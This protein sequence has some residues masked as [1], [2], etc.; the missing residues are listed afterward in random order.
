VRQRRWRTRRARR[1]TVG[2]LLAVG[3]AA[4]V[5]VAILVNRPA[6]RTGLRLDE[7]LSAVTDGRV[8]SATI[9]DGSH[10]VEGDLV[11]R[12]RYRVVVPKDYL[13]E[14][15]NTL[16]RA[17]P[18]IRLQAR[19]TGGWRS[20]VLRVVVPLVLIGGLGAVVLLRLHPGGAAR[21]RFG[22]A[23]ARRAAGHHSEGTFAD[24]AG[25]DEAVGELEEI[26]EFLR[27]PARFSALG[28]RIPKG[29][30]LHGPPGTGKTLLARAVA[31]EASA[32]FFAISGSD[33]VE[34][35]VGVGA[36]RVRDLFV[37]ATKAAPAIVFIDE[38]DAVGRSRGSGQGGG[39]DEREQT[40]NQLLVEMDGF[41]NHEGVIVLAASNRPDVLDPALL[42]PGRFDRHVPVDLP[43]VKS[44][45]AILQ[46]HA[47]NKP[48]APGVDVADVARRTPG[49]SGAELANLLNEAAILT[50]RRRRSVIGSAELDDALDR[51]MAGPTR[52]SRAMPE[53]ERWV[54]AYH[55]AG[56]AL[57]SH[58]LPTT[59]PVYKVSIL[60]RGRALG[61]TVVMPQ[62]ERRL[63][64]RRQLKE[65]MA[66]LLGGRTAEELVFGE[67]TSGASD[68]IE[69][70]SELARVMVTEY[71]MSEVIGL[72]RLSRRSD[73]SGGSG[74]GADAEYSQ[75]TAMLVDAEIDALV[76]GA[77]LQARQLL[78][79]HRAVLDCMA[80][81]LV[82]RETL[83]EADLAAIFSE[84]K[85]EADPVRETREWA[86]PTT[87]TP[88]RVPGTALV[89][90]REPPS[91]S[92]S[93]VR[94]RPAGTEQ[95]DVPGGAPGAFRPP[96]QERPGTTLDG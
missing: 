46:V 63:H 4:I 25:A 70:V 90:S 82:E 16:H 21:A 48:L 80:A 24:V 94:E 61:W 77:H 85:L 17:Q 42:R 72:R 8:V 1:L 23:R 37:K 79:R 40:L 9:S 57:V 22:R 45:H 89:A 58:V 39:H 29:V 38:I 52:Q 86:T 81:T 53:H 67:P 15:T 69:R 76:A 5:L 83:D 87:M 13:A 49:F 10:T 51:L 27:D 71:G 36:A 50:A 93:A 30:L 56:H 34:M 3:A 43:D 32:S 78:E 2:A 92:V 28:A 84:I 91:A 7:F 68:D 44:R 75:S 62:E 95:T 33:F 55:E 88:G 59:D 18:P 96:V 12:S 26:A 47:R 31:G 66:M 64:T 14:L 35:F 54:V 73:S 20:E 74:G 6:P 65:R 60:A 41:D 11:G 19:A